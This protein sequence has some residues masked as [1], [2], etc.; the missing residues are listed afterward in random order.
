MRGV[1][2]LHPRP[3]R[4][5]LRLRPPAL[6]RARAARGHARNARRRQEDRWRDHRCALSSVSAIS[7]SRA[8]SSRA[9]SSSSSSRCAGRRPARSA[10]PRRRS[11]CPRA[12]SHASWP[13]TGSRWRSDLGV[14][15]SGGRGSG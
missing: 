5:P 7:R 4:T 15:C 1:R 11:W 6:R 2:Q 8:P 14:R 9:R 10:S 13:C 12:S 3:V